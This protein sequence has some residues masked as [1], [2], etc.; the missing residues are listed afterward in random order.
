LLK[1]KTAERRTEQQTRHSI[2]VR[3][4]KTSNVFNLKNFTNLER[5]IKHKYVYKDSDVIEQEKKT[6]VIELLLQSFIGFCNVV[7]VWLSERQRKFTFF[8]V[9]LKGKE[10]EEDECPEAENML[11]DVVGWWGR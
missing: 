7:C 1:C 8:I 3:N 4:R 11:Q 10:R 9:Y 5:K 6:W 2:P